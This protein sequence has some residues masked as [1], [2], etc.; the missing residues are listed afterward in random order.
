MCRDMT[1]ALPEKIDT[2]SRPS[3]KGEDKFSPIYPCQSPLTV[4]WYLSISSGGYAIILYVYGCW[5]HSEGKDC[6][7][8]GLLE[9]D[10]SSAVK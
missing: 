6:S 8:I 4:I 1:Y 9:I 2:T 10:D 5:Y 3:A 7:W